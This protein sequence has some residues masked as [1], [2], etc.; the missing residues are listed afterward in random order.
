[1]SLCDNC[2]FEDKIGYCCSSHPETGETKELRTGEGLLFLVCPN[3]SQE[4]NCQIYENRPEPCGE[5]E[6]PRMYEIDLVDYF[7]NR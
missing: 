7:R 3:L 5:Y 4:G 2:D 6:C 1:M